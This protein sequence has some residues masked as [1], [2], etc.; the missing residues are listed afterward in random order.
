VRGKGIEIMTQ[1]RWLLILWLSLLLIA[2][3]DASQSENEANQSDQSDVVTAENVPTVGEGDVRIGEAAPYF[4]LESVDGRIVDLNEMKGK[5]VVLNFWATWCGPCRAEMPELQATYEAHHDD[6]LEL[7]GIEISKSG[8]ADQS[9]IFLKQVGATFPNVRD[10][11]SLMEQRY[12]KR[13]A[14]PTTI[15]IDA[16][17]KVSYIQLGPMNKQ[18][19]EE[20]LNDLGF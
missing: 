14:Y 4:R 2:C 6:G 9:A 7:I 3:G 8:N 16:E 1:R 13:P 20:R 18:F 17:G 10:Q 12:V 5:A 15:F 19:I 11:E